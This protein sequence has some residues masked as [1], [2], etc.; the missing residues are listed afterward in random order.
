MKP[1]STSSPESTSAM[2][3]VESL[4]LQPWLLNG[5]LES[6]EKQEVLAHLRNCKA[7]RAAFADTRQAAELL[8][9]HV[10]SMAIVEYA[11]GLVPSESDRDQIEKHLE[12]CLS[13]RQEVDWVMAEQ[14]IASDQVIDFQ[15]ARQ[16][17]AETALDGTAVA[18]GSD[19]LKSNYGST[20]SQFQST[21][22]HDWAVAATVTLALGAGAF[23]ISDRTEQAP[24]EPSP[25]V[26][27]LEVKDS[28]HLN[29]TAVFSDGFELGNTARWSST[30]T[31]SH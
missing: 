13:C 18:S 19:S 29:A 23:L 4:E 17:L 6:G 10:P 7:C 1:A 28:A 9:Q 25:A 15:T 3:C 2:S 26:A 20:P 31:E 12:S 11:Q 16:R 8:T 21:P 22:S 24:A 27:S 5:S 30:N 14:V